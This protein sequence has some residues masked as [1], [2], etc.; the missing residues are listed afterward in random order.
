MT[1]SPLRTAPLSRRQWLVRGGLGLAVLGGCGL[2]LS[3]LFA[4]EQVALRI[5]A[6]PKDHALRPV[7]KLTAESLEELKKVEDY[8]AVLVK[9]EKIGDV[10]MTA[11]LNIKCRENPRSVYIKFLEPHAGREV[12]YRPD[13]NNG[14]LLVHDTGLAALIGTL[15]LDPAGTLAMQENR[16]PISHIGL[17][18]LMEMCLEQWLKETKIDDTTVN[19]YPNAK[20][21]GHPCKV[22]EVSHARRHPDVVNHMTR[23]YLDAATKLPIRIQNYDYPIAPGEKPD[24]VEDYYYMDLRTNVGLKDEDFSQ[25]NGGYGF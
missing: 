18:R 8:T 22:I 17:K 16:H 2:A 15:S 19:Y 5:D 6:T 25:E 11:R 4:E 24:L 1:P 3:P 7:L 13:R 21:A 20:I 10:L 12:I 9:N 14:M 23:L